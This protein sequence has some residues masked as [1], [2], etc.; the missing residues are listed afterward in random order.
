[1]AEGGNEQ[2]TYRH[3]PDLSA[4]EDGKLSILSEH[5]LGYGVDLT[6]ENPWKNC[7]PLKARE[8][9][10]V[11]D[12][13]QQVEQGGF[14]Q[15]YHEIKSK[16]SINLSVSTTL[17]AVEYIKAGVHAKPRAVLTTLY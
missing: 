13:K 17:T 7:G 1:M 6:N 4:L 9:N 8:I 10:K 5:G 15:Y 12:V 11:S 2:Y 3:I 14:S 16:E